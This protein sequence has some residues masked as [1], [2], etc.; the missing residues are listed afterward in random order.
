MANVGMAPVWT[1]GDGIC[2]AMLTAAGTAFDGP[3]YRY[4]SSPGP[5]HSI[6]L[7]ITQGFSPLGEWGSTVLA[8]DA[9]AI[10]DWQNLDTG[11]SGTVSQHVPVTS[12][13]TFPKF[14]YVGTGPGRVRLTMRTD[15]PSIPVT[16][17]VVVP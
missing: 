7:R 3:M 9:T 15:H 16:T 2:P 6:E 13:S 5:S 1:L 14:V 4:G 10:I 17:D 12:T 8:C 11:Q